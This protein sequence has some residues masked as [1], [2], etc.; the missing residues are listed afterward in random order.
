MISRR[1]RVQLTVFGLL[2]ATAVGM[3]LFH[4]VNS[5]ALVGVGQVSASAVFED[6]AGIYP[7]ANVTYRGVTVGKVTDVRLD[8]E[9][10]RVT[11]R[12]PK[13][14][15][16]PSDV[17]ATVRSVSAI[18]EQYVDLVPRAD[19]S[20][21]PLVKGTVIPRDQTS[22]PPQIA[23]VLDDVN[24]LVESVPLA[25]LNTALN[26]ADLA[27]SDLG[28][29]LDSL[30]K[31]GQKLIEAADENYDATHQLLADGETFLD[32][33]LASS[34]S[35]RAL[36][37]DLAGFSTSLRGGDKD[38][39]A[40]LTSVPGAANQARLTVE[41]LGRNLPPLIKSGQVLADLT[42]DYHDPL[43]QVL[44]YYP[45]VMATNTAASSAS[46]DV[47]RMAFKVMANYPGGGC[48]V[49][50]PGTDDPLGPRGPN[51][52]TD[53]DAAP[54]TYCKVPQSDQRIT[55]GAR[56]LQCFE[57]GS[58]PGKRAA[59][60]YQCRGE[61]DPVGSVSGSSAPTSA[62]Q[63]FDVLSFLGGQG[64]TPPKEEMTWQNLLA[65]P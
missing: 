4:Y 2:T 58:A 22:V 50:Y 56:N 18:G 16:I 65:A 62:G 51:D 27:F 49:G 9:G 32:S 3:I 59:T 41:L 47:Q 25:D 7:Q 12:V 55:R 35:I 23:Q 53:I 46:P 40:L 39:R 15:D 44:V 34:D 61:A 1:I 10:V 5:P 24:G 11:F 42:A 19:S 20:S 45:R 30:T 17:S 29:K 28:P 31:N 33:Q 26:E 36:T 14:A 57:P 54:N 21:K 52:L 37:K 13:S 43:E 8:P 48:K 60:I 6:G 38:F 63:S 64:A